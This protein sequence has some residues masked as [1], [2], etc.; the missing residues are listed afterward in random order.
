MA[1][2]THVELNEDGTPLVSRFDEFAARH[3][4]HVL[5]ML[6]YLAPL[7]LGLH[8][9]D[10]FTRSPLV[11]FIAMFT[12]FVASVIAWIPGFLIVGIVFG[13]FAFT[14]QVFRLYSSS[15]FAI[16]TA[17]VLLTLPIARFL[18]RIINRTALS[19]FHR[20]MF[21]CGAVIL[22]IAALASSVQYMNAL[23]NA[24]VYIFSCSVVSI[25]Y[26][27]V[28]IISTKTTERR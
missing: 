7:T 28:F 2:R 4:M 16:A 3:L 26:F 5:A 15:D 8:Y 11:N 20:K 12:G 9:D 22:M 27:A 14:K 23:G 24:Y 1:H 17:L 25:I 19:Y 13:N 6:F 10:L 21:F 18:A